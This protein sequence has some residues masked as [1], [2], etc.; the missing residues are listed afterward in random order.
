MRS[1][2]GDVFELG[3]D[4]ILVMVGAVALIVLVNGYFLFTGSDPVFR[5]RRRRD[6]G[7]GAGRGQ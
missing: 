5:L 2:G 4:E 7:S 1:S 6:G 3:V